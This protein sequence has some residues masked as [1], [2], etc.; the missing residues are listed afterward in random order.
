MQK[1]DL[2]L[3]SDFM[4]SVVMNLC[5]NLGCQTLSEAEFLLSRVLD[6]FAMAASECFILTEDFPWNRLR[7]GA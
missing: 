7:G 1:N 5:D 2:R 3:Q 4:Q 6:S